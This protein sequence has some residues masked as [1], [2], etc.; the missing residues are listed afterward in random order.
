MSLFYARMTSVEV[1]D[2]AGD[3]VADVASPGPAAV[4]P[5]VRRLCSPS[6]ARLLAGSDHRADAG[7]G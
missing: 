6:R 2:G 5:T 7:S 1:S 4:A 3:P